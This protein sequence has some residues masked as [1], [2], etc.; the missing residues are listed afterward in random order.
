VPIDTT[1]ELRFDRY[2]LPSTAVRQ[3]ILF[4]SGRA[5]NPPVSGVVPEITPAYDPLERVVRYTLP[6]GATLKPNTLYTVEFQVA[7][8]ITVPARHVFYPP[9]GFRAFDGAPLDEDGV[10]RISF[11]TGQS[12]RRAPEPEP[13]PT[14]DD[15][16]ALFRCEGLGCAS[17]SEGCVTC[18]PG[19]GEHADAAG[20][21]GLRLRDAEALLDTAIGH[22]AH[23]TEIGGTTGRA[24]EAAPRF[25]AQM[26]VIDP[27]RP[28]NSYLF[29]KI[30]ASHTA[31]DFTR[32]GRADA[33]TDVACD[34]DYDVATIGDESAADCLAPDRAELDRLNEWF[35]VGE[36][37]PPARA[38]RFLGPVEV[39]KLGAWIRAGAVC[40]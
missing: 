32:G 40:P 24:L 2:L 18:H 17:P 30:L 35:I 7:G 25:G 38:P 34:S 1:I 16:L 20:P 26:P 21:H 12:R 22:V 13:V 14:C 10:R 36:P 29:Y 9:W 5:L 11:R 15:V 4:Y 3:S 31:Y 37:M 6:S 33:G 27:G 19:V 23:Q 8:P 28:D 39:R